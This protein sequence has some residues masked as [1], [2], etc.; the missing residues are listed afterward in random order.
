MIYLLMTEV[1]D[2]KKIGQISLKEAE[3]ENDDK[4]AL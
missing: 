4:F 3:D 2:I 1:W